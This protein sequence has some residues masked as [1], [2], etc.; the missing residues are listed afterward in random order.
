MLLGWLSGWSSS[1]AAGLEKV[2][3]E[4][5]AT[6]TVGNTGVDGIHESLAR[7]LPAR[8]HSCS[9]L[10]VV[11]PAHCTP[12][13]IGLALEV[14]WHSQQLCGLRHLAEDMRYWLRQRW[15]EKLQS[16]GLG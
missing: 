16:V 14:W 2:Q 9:S 7:A 8:T 3:V 13:E 6:A 5:E 10:L 11:G 12:G 1:L 4:L 15:R